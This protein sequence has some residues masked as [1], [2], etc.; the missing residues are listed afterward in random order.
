MRREGERSSMSDSIELFQ[1]TS[2]DER[3]LFSKAI[4]ALLTKKDGRL[5]VSQGQKDPPLK[6]RITHVFRYMAVLNGRHPQRGDFGAGTQDV[7]LEPG[8]AFLM[9]QGTWRVPLQ[10]G[11]RSILVIHFN[12]RF[13]T[14]SQYVFDE[15]GNVAS[16]RH[17]STAQDL[18][19]AG[20]HLLNALTELSGRQPLPLFCQP[21]VTCLLSEVKHL[22]HQDTQPMKKSEAT[23]L[24]LCN[25]VQN[26]FREPI[27]RESAAAHLNIHPVH[28]SR[29]FRS[30]GRTTF[31]DYLHTRRMEHAVKLME[32]C[33]FL[34]IKEI[35]SSCGF[36]GTVYFREVFREM[37]GMSP[38]AYRNAMMQPSLL[39]GR[40]R[41]LEAHV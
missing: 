11:K 6:A 4:A 8:D 22:L 41:S 30:L 3:L 39:S 26:Q 25:Y 28:V 20:T 36:N 13:L 37:K 1:Q 27:N 16:Q 40:T 33:P 17:F 15:R 23:F 12:L 18:T 38:Q 34:N 10:G 31:H 19:R 32:D 24:A 14:L 29:L 9:R 7:W 21:L 2:G 5:C 35:A